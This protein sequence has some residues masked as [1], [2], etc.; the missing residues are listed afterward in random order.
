MRAAMTSPDVVPLDHSSA[1]KPPRAAATLVVVRDAPGGL[2][3]LLLCRAERGDHNSGAWVFPGGTVDKTDAQWRSL[4]DGSDDAATST[5]LGIAEGGLDYAITA[6]RECFEECGLLF[7]RRAGAL[8]GDDSARLAPWRAPLN[9]GERSLGEFCAAEGLR[10]AV[11]E[12]A[13]FSHWLTPLGRAKRYDTRF[14]VAVAPAGQAAQHDGT[15]M[16]GMH[17][18]RP[19][20]AL[21]RSD[22]LKLMGPTR[23]TLSAIGAFNDT[24]ALMAYA[25]GPRTVSLINPRIG[26]GSQ[27]L[28][29][30]MPHEHAWAEMGRIDPLG[31]GTA[32]YEI[33]PGR[34][35]KLS[36]HVIRVTAPNPSVMT[37]P[38]TNTY[39]VGGGAANEWAVI[40][41]GPDLPEHVEAVLHA[42]P[43]PIRWIL[44]THTHHD[45]SPASVPLRQHTHAPVMGRLA[46]HPHKQDGSFAPDRVLEHGERLSIA[47]GVTLRVLH[48]PG[49]A[50]NHLCYLLEEEK[51][52]FTGDHLMQSSTVVINPPDGD[53]AAYLRTLRA[54]LNEDIE[55][56]APGHGFLMAQPHLAVQAVIDHR[57]KRE[58]KV[59]ATLRVHAPATLEQLL[60]HAYDDVD[61]RL[62]PVAARS[63][64]AHLD[65]LRSDG[66]AT[67]VA[68]HWR[69][70]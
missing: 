64:L 14:F 47:P 16:V 27:G 53:M 23:A 51:T 25:R 59:L 55:W 35:V 44:A 62:L 50:S 58:A 42:A 33:V 32:S 8:L 21:A 30:V 3:V 48:T 69:V 7:A 17:W 29:P 15:E 19:A 68:G 2:Q 65:K 22:S 28:R 31:H 24:A 41:P 56:L 61:P 60:P 6:I 37:G 38:G 5:R 26:A 46:V 49:H 52:L 18:L 70:A 66:V 40:D 13:Y 43:G 11:D 9:A 34:A 1:D 12:L 63:L 39:L 10:L 45:H 36:P 20:D 67:E 54:L 57:L 4:C